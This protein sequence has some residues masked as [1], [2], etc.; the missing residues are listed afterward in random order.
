MDAFLLLLSELE[1]EKQEETTAKCLS[2]VTGTRKDYHAAGIQEKIICFKKTITTGDGCSCHTDRLSA[3]A[4][5][6]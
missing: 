6:L 3:G 1:E 2:N 5:S 4:L